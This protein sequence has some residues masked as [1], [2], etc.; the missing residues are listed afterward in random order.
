MVPMMRVFLLLLPLVLPGCLTFSG[1]KLAPITPPPARKRS[2]CNAPAPIAFSRALFLARRRELITESAMKTIARYALILAALVASL[3]AQGNCDITVGP[4][5]GTRTISVDMDAVTGG[6]VTVTVDGTSEVLK[7]DSG[8][9]EY[10]LPVGGT[11][12]IHSSNGKWIDI[13]NTGSSYTVQRGNSSSGSDA[14]GPDVD[15]V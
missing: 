6:T 12:R 5:P 13:T 14:T 4:G 8:K 1:D 15:V 2:A 11:I 3:S 7:K 10:P 9:K